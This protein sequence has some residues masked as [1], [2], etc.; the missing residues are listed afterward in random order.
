MIVP[1]FH[2]SRLL[3]G[4]IALSLLGTQAAQ[5]ERPPCI[6]PHDARTLI[7]IA[8]PDAIDGLVDRCKA[9]L[10]ADAFLPNEGAGLAQRFRREAPVDPAQARQA[11]QAATGQD[12][13]SLASDETVTTLAR[14]FV[15]Q[16]IAD[17]V[18]PRNCKS[19]DSMVELAAPLR[20]N[21]MSEAILLALEVAGPEQTKGLAICRP[22][23]EG[24][25]Q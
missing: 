3:A 25:P 16:Q 18:P 4:A 2:R 23:D 22:K 11:I 17:H 20:A 24:A 8:L 14:Q 15:G 21:A 12:L 13:S 7:R 1:S 9:A 19:I 5:A 6:A 10:P